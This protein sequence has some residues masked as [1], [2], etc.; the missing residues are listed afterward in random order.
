MQIDFC[1]DMLYYSRV[2]IMIYTIRG[3]VIIR[4]DSLTSTLEFDYT[5]SPAEEIFTNFPVPAV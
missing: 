3:C 4:N 5:T 1:E 2:E